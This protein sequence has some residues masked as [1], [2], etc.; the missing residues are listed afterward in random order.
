MNPKEYN[1]PQE[2][3]VFAN[4]D[5]KIHDKEL[6]TKPVSY[7]KDAFRRFKK[8]KASIV[9]A[10]IICILFF[11][12][13]FGPL[14]TPYEVSYKDVN[15][16]F[17]LPRNSLF[18]K[19]G[20]PFWDGGK[21][22]E[23]NE[24]D[25]NRYLYTEMETNLDIIMNDNVQIIER[26]D[27][28]GKPQK[29]FKY[30]LDTYTSVGVVL[31][32]GVS[33][34]MYKEIQKYQDETGIQVIYPITQKNKR[35]V[36]FE[37]DGNFWYETKRVGNQT[38]AVL[39]P[40]GT[41]KNMYV[42]YTNGFDDYTSSVR[43]EGDTP[44]YDYARKE[45]NSYEIR[46]NYYEYYKFYHS[47]HL[48]DG[49]N[50]PSFLFGTNYDGHD[51]FIRLASGAR[52]SFIFAIIVASINLFIGAIYGAIEGY[53]GGKIDI[54]MERL[55]E[56]LS[57]IPFMVVITL[58]NY[59]MRNSSQILILIVAFFLTGWIGIAG[60]TRMQFYRFKNQEYVLAARTLGAK[61]KRIMFKHIFPNAL[62]TLITSC[63]LII[64]SMIFSETSL[65]YLGIINLNSD[66]LTSVGFLLSNAQQYM[67]TAPHYI[68]FPALFI[69]LLM[70][71]FNLFGNGLRDA[72][73]PSLRGSED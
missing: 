41:P 15:Y 5:D 61:D 59:H 47:Y 50:E 34:E 6:S 24:A 56:I 19:M 71:S 37:G 58:L 57:A 35:P 23:T 11:Y 49:I 26:I 36:N 48:Q 21:K 10:I 29:Y 70:L 73:N 30:R 46:V 8:N 9:A 51:I 28:L 4:K 43:I 68:F 60:R 45:Q 25:Y 63:V 7:L 32:S 55:V 14:F 12:A 64:P 31:M 33:E 20:V 27:H 38:Q 1:I 72:F 13:F 42:K 2:K 39:N 22:I 40:D 67:T 16:R 52:F 17:A 54:V 66:T 18:V 3:F 65:S 62:G 53:Y 69:C 44:Q